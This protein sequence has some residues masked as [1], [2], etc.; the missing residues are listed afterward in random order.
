MLGFAQAEQDAIISLVSSVLHIGNIQFRS[1]GDRSC[2]VVAT[3]SANRT[4]ALASAAK[5]M[6]V[7]TIHTASPATPCRA[8]LTAII[9]FMST[10]SHL[11][12][13]L[14]ARLSFL[15]ECNLTTHPQIQPQVLSKAL[16]VQTLR[17][18]G[19]ANTEIALSAK[20][21]LDTCDVLAKF[22][23]GALFTWIVQKIN[24]AIVPP[25]GKERAKTIGILDIFGFEI[26][27]N[28]SFEQLCINYTNEKLQQHFN[29]HT[30]K[31]EESV[32]I[33]E[34]IKFDK[35]NYIDNQPVLDLIEQVRVLLTC[36]FNAARVQKVN[37]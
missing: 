20:E 13:S 31:L 8:Q 19:Q 2:E 24:K 4:D 33:Q 14:L 25:A 21:A 16:T 3:A 17:I 27:E 12:C 35:I 7:R 28:N 26:F 9:D 29:Q 15:H 10:F 34:G 11:R 22:L 23:F 6:Q 37:L 32:Y 18:Q 30:F 5:L 1:T 36:C